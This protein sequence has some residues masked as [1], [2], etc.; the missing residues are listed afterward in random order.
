MSAA[1]HVYPDATL[2]VNGIAMVPALHITPAFVLVITGVGLT[3]TVTVCV[4]PP[5]LFAEDVIV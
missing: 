4:L 5:Q 1:I 2:L 3:V